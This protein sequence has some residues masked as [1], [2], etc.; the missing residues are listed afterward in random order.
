MESTQVIFKPGGVIA[1]VVVSAAVMTAIIVTF[2]K[3]KTPAAGAATTTVGA[4]S[5]SNAPA[6]P[7]APVDPTALKDEALLADLN[8]DPGQVRDWLF[9]GALPS[10]TAI[11]DGARTEENKA[12]MRKIIA[13]SYLPT[14]TKYRARENQLVTLNGADYKW[15]KVKG[16]GFNF[17]EIFKSKEAPSTPLTNVVV[18]GYTTIDSKETTKKN[19][20]FRSDDGAIV[21]VNGQKVYTGNEIRGVD[22]ENVIPIDLHPGQNNVLV[23]VGQGT[24]GWGMAFQLEDLP[25]K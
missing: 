6:V 16:S 18:Y 23:K 3:D 12:L 19:L 7:V 17:H 10:G 5:K 4:A 20:H 1:L 22:D 9:L 14:E 24:N 11:P 13:T 21:W 25:G 2:G 15:Q 8:K